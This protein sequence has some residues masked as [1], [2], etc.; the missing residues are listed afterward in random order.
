[1]T[2]AGPGR[3]GFGMATANSVSNIVRSDRIGVRSYFREGNS[4]SA[5]SFVTSFA[6]IEFAVIRV[7]LGLER[8]R[9]MPTTRLSTGHASE[10]TRTRHGRVLNVVPAEIGTTPEEPQK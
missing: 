1:M 5:Q 7:I 10:A 8:I 3:K 2:H 9:I 6:G 4:I